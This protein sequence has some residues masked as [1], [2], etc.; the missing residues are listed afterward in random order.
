MFSVCDFDREAYNNDFYFDLVVKERSQQ[1]DLEKNDFTSKDSSVWF[2]YNSWDDKPGESLRGKGSFQ[3]VKKG[4][5]LLWSSKGDDLENT[6]Y[7]VCFWYN[8][9]IDRADL[10]SIV[11]FTY[12]DGSKSD[13]VS[14]FDIKQSTHIVRNWMQVEMDFT[15]TEN[16]DEIKLFICGNDSGEP[17]VVDELLVRKTD[18]ANLFNHGQI[19]GEKFIIYNNYWISE[20]SFSK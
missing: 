5:D 19:G 7:T 2:H 1:I 6:N 3:S 9:F 12:K 18:G 4:Y 14:R 8:Y 15:V 16:V 10:M 20:E 13:W 17:Y 11:E